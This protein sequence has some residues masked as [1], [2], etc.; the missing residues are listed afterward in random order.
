[1]FLL[2]LRH[3]EAKHGGL[4]VEEEVSQRLRQLG[5]TCT[6]RAKE[7]ERTHGLSFLVQTR[8]ALE[9]SVENTL[10]GVVLTYDALVQDLLGVAKLLALLALDVTHRNTRHLSHNVAD[11]ILLQFLHLG[12]FFLLFCQIGHLVGNLHRRHSAVEQVESG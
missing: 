9:D 3:I 6:S 8:T 2:V 5:L 12:I 10:D 11:G 7:E 4:V 1:M